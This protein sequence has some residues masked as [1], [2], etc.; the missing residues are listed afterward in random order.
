MAYCLSLAN[1]TMCPDFGGYSAYIGDNLA[2][3]ITDIAGFDRYIADSIS[4]DG[5]NPASFASGM[6]SSEGLGFG[7]SGWDS[8]TTGL[9]YHQ[10]ALCAAFAASGSTAPQLACN[11]PGGGGGGAAVK[12]CAASMRAFVDSFNAVAANRTLCPAP[13]TPTA[14]A[15]VAFFESQIPVLSTPAA[16]CSVAQASDRANCGFLTAAES[17]AFCALPASKNEACCTGSFVPGSPNFVPTIGNATTTS[18]AAATAAPNT[19]QTTATSGTTLPVPAI[20]GAGG[21]ALLLMIITFVCICTRKTRAARK[22]QAKNSDLGD[23]ES[24]KSLDPGTSKTKN[25]TRA[26]SMQALPKQ[27]APMGDS[28]YQPE[29]VSVSNNNANA[30]DATGQFTRPVSSGKDVHAVVFSYVPDLGDELG[31]TVGDMIIVKE[32]YEDGWAYGLNTKTMAEGFFPLGILSGYAELQPSS[33]APTPQNQSVNSQEGDSSGGNRNSFFNNRTSSLFGDV[34]AVPQIPQSALNNGGT[35]ARVNTNDS[36]NSTGSSAAAPRFG[37]SS[38]H[39]AQSLSPVLSPSAI[40]ALPSVS[41]PDPRP[42]S[43]NSK[44]VNRPPKAL[45]TPPTQLPS[46]DILSNAAAHTPVVTIPKQQPAGAA[47]SSPTTSSSSTTP[48]KKAFKVRIVM[49]AFVP[50]MPDEIELRVGDQIQLDQE[51]DGKVQRNGW[52]TGKNLNTGAEGVLPLDCL[53]GYATTDS[54]Q[55]VDDRKHSQRMSSLY[56]GDSVGSSG[57]VVVGGGGYYGSSTLVGDS[58]G[59]NSVDVYKSS[60]EGSNIYQQ[61]QYQYQVPE[62][63]NSNNI[64]KLPENDPYGSQPAFD[65]FSNENAYV[66][67]YYSGGVGEGTTGGVDNLYFQDYSSSGAGRR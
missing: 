7:C 13:P 11:A 4:L 50:E 23:V 6:R 59:N 67:N 19:S 62:G 40:T 32:R 49:Y 5:S 34:P 60:S 27:A 18:T 15:F 55:Q 58:S 54:M 30:V 16:G 25:V 45:P 66:S 14:L 52:G 1:S 65:P 56:G 22:L 63:S 10:S 31:A 39:A 47:A 61:Y 42:P 8:R 2:P 20:A 44:T 48:N 51:F 21:G 53:M 17:N 64:Y 24:V 3:Q 12:L 33:G 26:I 29:Y 57:G 43:S 41:K 28:G 37:P 9:R 46:P 35:I 38:T 36:A